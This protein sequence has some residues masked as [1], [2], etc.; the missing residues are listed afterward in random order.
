[1]AGMLLPVWTPDRYACAFGSLRAQ[2]PSHNVTHTKLWNQVIEALRGA[3]FKF[4][5]HQNIHISKKQGFTKF[6]VDEFKNMGQ[7]SSSSLAAVGPNISPTVASRTNG[8]PCS[9]DTLGAV[10]SLLMPPIN[11]TFLSKKWKRF[12]C[13]FQ[14]EPQRGGPETLTFLFK[15]CFYFF[16]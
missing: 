13:D 6:N 11:P 9:H 10:L 8:R 14:S 3:K 4:P 2:R 1:M 12:S 7:K 16:F 5:G 15:S